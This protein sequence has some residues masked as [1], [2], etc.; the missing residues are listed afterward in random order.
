MNIVESKTLSTKAD[1]VA[2]AGYG[3]PIVIA[4]ANA[5][6]PTT[7]RVGRAAGA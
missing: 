4:A 6:R 5:K 1:P 3:Q 7:D 2:L